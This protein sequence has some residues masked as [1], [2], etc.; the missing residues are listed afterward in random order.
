VV[1]FAPPRPGVGFALMPQ[2]RRCPGRPGGVGGGDRPAQVNHAELEEVQDA[3]C[4]VADLPQAGEAAVRSE[5]RAADGAGHNQNAPPGR[6]MREQFLSERPTGTHSASRAEE[7]GQRLHGRPDAAAAGPAG[8][9]DPNPLV[10]GVAAGR[11]VVVV[12]ARR[13]RL[14]QDSDDVVSRER[15]GGHLVRRRAS[16]SR[17]LRVPD[18]GLPSSFLDMTESGPSRTGGQQVMVRE[19]ELVAELYLIGRSSQVRTASIGDQH[20]ISRGV[21]RE[22]RTH[23]GGRRAA[24]KVGPGA[25]GAVGMDRKERFDRDE[26]DQIAV[27]GMWA[28]ASKR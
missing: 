20:G 3:G 25:A 1:C 13:V 15:G 14:A 17:T 26:D 27:T 19:L 6:D 5:P 18:M 12:G 11:L 8:G 10:A 24:A 7:R 16:M 28:T 4:P 21:S 22:G 23:C 2:D 9:E